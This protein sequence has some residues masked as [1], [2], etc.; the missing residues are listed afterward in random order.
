MKLLRGI[1]TGLDG[2]ELLVIATFGTAL[3]LVLLGVPLYAAYAL[4][5]VGRPYLAGMA[6]LLFVAT[7]GTAIRD[8]RRS[9]I[10]WVSAGVSALWLGSVVYVA[11]RVLIQ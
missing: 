9:R 8:M 2:V 3:F 1:A 10:S 4:Y 11:A 6:A 5:S 7:V